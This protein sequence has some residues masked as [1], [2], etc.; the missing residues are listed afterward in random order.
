MTSNS[1]V[2][3][4]ENITKIY[5]LGEIGTGF[6]L[7]DLRRW[8]SLKRGHEDPFSI[9]GHHQKNFRSSESNTILALDDISFEV[10]QGEVIGIIGK[11]GA[12]KSTILKIL[13]KITKP[14]RGTITLY[15]RV[16][17]LLEIGTGFHPELTGMENIFLNGAILGMRKNEI[18]TCL[19]EII[20][21][22]GVEKYIHTPVKRFSSG[23]R[24]RLGFAVAAHLRSDILVV[25]EV[26]AV[27]DAEFQRKAIGRMKEASVQGGR[28]VLFV[29]HNTTS[30]LGLCSKAIYLDRG[31]ITMIGEPSETIQKYL[32]QSI[33]TENKLNLSESINLRGNNDIK[34]G[35][36]LV[37]KGK[38]SV[39]LNTDSTR[40]SLQILTKDNIKG[41]CEIA[42]RIRDSNGLYL[43]YFG[44]KLK[45]MLFNIQQEE[46]WIHVTFNNLPFN[47]GTYLF[48]FEIKISGIILYRSASS[49]E[50]FIKDN[51]FY[52][53][54]VIWNRGKVLIEQEWSQS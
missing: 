42:G 22:S 24:V 30:V 45:S 41:K 35:D 14:T 21:F 15:G 25:D 12:G 18:K 51:D 38:N 46:T 50:I 16:A 5:N 17:S 13:S 9:L 53:T 43:H 26:L 48:D 19:E 54:G 1:T 23:M 33:K 29:S 10:K 47:E 34:I 6:F 4:A 20:D 11:N 37:N 7:N 3:K 2:I 8:W 32:S 44:S 31:K 28:T 36:V 52:N 49:V 27:G 40:I 39:V